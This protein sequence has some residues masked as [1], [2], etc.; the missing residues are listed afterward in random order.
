MAA[1]HRVP[2]MVRRAGSADV[3]GTEGARSEEIGWDRLAA[4][5]RARPGEPLPEGAAGA[6]EGT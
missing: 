6:A 5:V 4:A 3:L 1:G 2:E